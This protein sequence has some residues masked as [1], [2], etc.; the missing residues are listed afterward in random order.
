MPKK[1]AVSFENTLH[2]LEDIIDTLESG[3]IPLEQAMEKFGE[4]VKLSNEC[5]KALNDA[6]KKVRILIDKNLKDYN[7]NS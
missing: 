4:G 3:E 5:Q 2:D 6:E 1:T 7:E